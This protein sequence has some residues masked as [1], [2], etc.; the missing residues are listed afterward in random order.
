MN[1]KV[2]AILIKGLA[3]TEKLLEAKTKQLDEQEVN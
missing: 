2:P 1:I 3:I